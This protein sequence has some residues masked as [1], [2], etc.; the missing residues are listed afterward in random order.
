MQTTTASRVLLCPFLI[1]IVLLNACATR[2]SIQSNVRSMQTGPYTTPNRT[3]T[4]FSQ[5]LRC[6]DDLLLSYQIPES[7][8]I[9]EELYDNTGKVSVGT[10]DMLI[11]A[12]AN[13][14]RRSNA[15]RLVAYGRDSSNAISFLSNS[16]N[17]S[18]YQRQ[19]KYGIRG[20]ISQ[21]DTRVSSERLGGGLSAKKWGLGGSRRVN[22][23]IMGID[24]NVVRMRDLSIIPMA[25]SSNQVIL[26]S[27][28][29]SFDG[30]AVIKKLGFNFNFSSDK[31]EGVS[32]A[33][34]N[35]IDL[36]AIELIGRLMK[37]PYWQCLNISTDNPLVA[38]E[39]EDWMR[40]FE[41]DNVLIPYVRRVLSLKGIYDLHSSDSQ[42]AFQNAVRAYQQSHGY[43]QTGIVDVAFMQLLLDSNPSSKS[44]DKQALIA[45]TTQ[46]KTEMADSSLAKGAHAS[47]S[48]NAVKIDIQVQGAAAA[49]EPGPIDFN[50][51]L[52][53]DGFI[54]CYYSDVDKKIQRF[55]PNRFERNNFVKKNETLQ[56][57]GDMPFIIE[58]NPSEQITCYATRREIS[59]SLPLEIQGVDFE[60]LKVDSILNI[61][62]AFIR[63]TFS[64]IGEATYVIAN[65]PKP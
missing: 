55:F 4:N 22:G 10:R 51:R 64:P 47:H 3:I 26:L 8:F 63:A 58:A 42:S 19:P 54:Y 23:D 61:K 32:Q 9:M 57:P 1:S 60:P 24:L 14:S 20:S 49:A 38:Q 43:P 17:T 16:G 53:Q 21:Y 34:R 31:N 59:Q 39:I 44:Q 29:S 45:Q 15:V 50:L 52:S 35:L 41:A 2:S 6:M 40:V 46:H 7:T 33:L 18:V 25:N 12:V 13:M 28:S 62:Q 48:P 5:S 56:L 11:T 30:D 65:Q 36:A 27:S 37:V